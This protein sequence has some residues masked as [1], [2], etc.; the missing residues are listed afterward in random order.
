[1]SFPNLID[2]EQLSAPVRED[3]PQGTD[4]REDRSPTSDYYTIKDARNN[5][6]AAERAALFEE[7][8]TDFMALWRTVR[9]TAENIL[10][11]TSKDL[12]V[13]SWYTESLIRLEGVTGLRDGF[14]LLHSLIREH[15]EGLYPEPDEDG[16][17]T[18]VAPL[19]GLNGDGGEG[20]LLTPIRNLGITPDGSFGEF[21]F[22][23][24]QQ[25]RDAARLE[26]EARAQREETLGYKMDEINTTIQSADITWCTNLI[27]TIDECI[28]EYKGLSNLLREHCQH[29]APPYTQI[30]DLLDEV[31]RTTRH[32]YKDKISAAEDAAA[33]QAAQNEAT[34]EAEEAVNTPAT[35]VQTQAVIPGSATG[36][37]THREEALKQLERVATYFRSYEPHTPITSSLER[38]ISWGRMSV[39][40]LMIELLPDS[41][42][43]SIYSQLTGVKLDGSD[44]T[45]YIAPPTPVVEAPQ[46][47]AQPSQ[48]Q[49]QTAPEQP[50]TNDLGW[51]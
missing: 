23:Q 16:L 43:R 44:N 49:E 2:L 14:S 41:D 13:A 34:E 20:T 9:S 25:A 35:E 11:D 3:A 37:I 45:Q 51:N 36:P 18:K 30:T 39:A 19:S 26:D 27:A 21:S 46:S 7:S 12:E 22:W 32:L 31:L 1:M 8:D 15:W 42:A 24:Y 5:A 10:S 28:T 50:A 6:R 40:E 17:E 38:L 29:D 48:A 33:A 4:I 47:T